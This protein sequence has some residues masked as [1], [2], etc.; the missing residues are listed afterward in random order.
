MERVEFVEVYMRRSP[1]DFRETC[2]EL[3]AEGCQNFACDQSAK[4]RTVFHV[5]K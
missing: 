4:L 3:L 1:A 5:V 2:C